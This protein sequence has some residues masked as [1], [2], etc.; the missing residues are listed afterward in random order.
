MIT[1]GRTLITARL[2]VVFRYWIVPIS[3]GFSVV[4]VEQATE[5]LPF[6]EGTI[7]YMIVGRLNER[8]AKALMRAL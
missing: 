2:L 5:S 8:T 7:A 4:I 6:D 3:C 1:A